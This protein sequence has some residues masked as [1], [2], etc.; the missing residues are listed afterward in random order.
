MIIGDESALE[1]RRNGEMP[2][3]NPDGTAPKGYELYETFKDVADLRAKVPLQL[4]KDTEEQQIARHIAR[5]KIDQGI[6][7]H[8]FHAMANLTE[9]SDEKYEFYVV[10]STTGEY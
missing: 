8:Y 3:L 1:R 2:P 5:N 10:N 4:Y 6:H 7:K 9:M